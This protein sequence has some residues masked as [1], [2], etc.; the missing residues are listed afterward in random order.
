M[1]ALLAL[2]CSAALVLGTWPCVGASIVSFVSDPQPQPLSAWQCNAQDGSVTQ[3][4]VI[5]DASLPCNRGLTEAA[6]TPSASCAGA[7]LLAAIDRKEI[8]RQHLQ[9]VLVRHTEDISWSV[10]EPADAPE[11]ASVVLPNVGREQHAYLTHIIRNYN[12]LVD[13]NQVG[14]HLLTNV[15]FLV[16]GDLYMPLTGCA[17]HDMTLSTVRSTF[18]D[19]LDTH[20]RVSRPVAAHPK[21]SNA[22][23]RGGD[24]W[25]K[26]EVN[27]LPKYAHVVGRFM[28]AGLRA[29]KMVDFDTVLHFAQGAQFAASRAALLSSS[30]P[31]ETYQWILELVE[32]GHLE[33]IFYLEMIWLYAPEA[34]WTATMADRKEAVPFAE[35]GLV[36]R[37]QTSIDSEEAVDLPEKSSVRTAMDSESH[38]FTRGAACPLQWLPVLLAISMSHSPQPPLPLLIKVDH[39]GA[40]VD[41][42][43][44]ELEPDAEVIII[45]DLGVLAEFAADHMHAGLA[46]DHTEEQRRSLAASPEPEVGLPSPPSPPS[47]PPSPP[48]L[49]SPPSS[50]PSAFTSTASLKAAVQVF[51]TN[52]TAA[53]ATYGPVADWDVSAITDMSVLFKKFKNFNAD[54]SSWDTSRV[55]NM[56]RMFHVRSTAALPSASMG[57]T[58]CP[59]LRTCFMFGPAPNLQSSPFL[60]TLLLHRGRPPPLPPPGPQLRTVST[61]FD[62]GSARLSSTSR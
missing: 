53:I 15:S 1:P 27:D 32:A 6:A 54:I 58:A 43:V 24:Q 12:F 5:V 17:N 44:G 13:P 28:Q 60:C 2:L 46:A 22:D 56:Y 23:E 59:W 39:P 31:K 50:P 3:D 35:A 40:K 34:D 7:E 21:A 51:N 37:A 57:S 11:A 16:E 25:L 38:F 9:L 8:N 30:T 45:E 49:P 18:A 42:G 61:S 14:N 55:T 19:G 10:Y 26:C 36:L 41:A 48:S 52:L 29:D 4:G 62:R 47:P 20:P 33:M